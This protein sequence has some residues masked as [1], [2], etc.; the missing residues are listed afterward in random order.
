MQRYQHPRRDHKKRWYI[1]NVKKRS[2]KKKSKNVQMSAQTAPKETITKQ[3]ST[4][5]Q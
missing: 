3:P 1:K 2:C 4:S 5:K